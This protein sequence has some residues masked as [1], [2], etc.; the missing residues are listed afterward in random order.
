[1][2]YFLE[3]CRRNEGFNWQL[4]SDRQDIPELPP[5]VSILQTGLKE[6]AELA[7]EKLKLRVHLDHSY[8]LCDLR[9]AYGLIFNNLIKDA[10]FWGYSDIDLIYGMFSSFLDDSILKDHDVISC[11]NDYFPGHFAV[12]RNREDT[13]RLFMKSPVYQTVFEDRKKHYAFDERSNFFGQTLPASNK[14]EK[15]LNK[16]RLKLNLGVPEGPR[17]MNTIINN[18]INTDSP[19]VYRNDLVRSDK[20]FT[21]RG[22]ENWEITWRDGRL[23]DS[24]SGEEL[25]HFHFLLSKK[26]PGFTV[27]PLESGTA[28]SISP[29]GI[30]PV[31]Q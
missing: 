8:K 3:S 13:N 12:F 6:L 7:S 19:R 31:S 17:D 28:F 1:M 21:K 10:D 4:V 26:Q 5:N 29:R 20:W 15:A 16:A 30:H 24:L 14:P 27:T 22:T 11:R 9:P 2:E 25:L 23:T 18:A